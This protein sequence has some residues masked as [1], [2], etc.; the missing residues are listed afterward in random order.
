MRTASIA[1]GALAF[2]VGSAGSTAGGATCTITGSEGMPPLMKTM[3]TPSA[4]DRD[5]PLSETAP[6]PRPVPDDVSP[7][8]HVARNFQCLDGSYLRRPQRWGR[9]KRAQRSGRRWQSY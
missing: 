1:T 2:F 9:R 4:S 3:A 6:Y 5:H 7:A 8:R